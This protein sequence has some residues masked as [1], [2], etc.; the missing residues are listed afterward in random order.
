MPPLPIIVDFEMLE[1]R[2][3]GLL[4]GDVD[5]SS[6]ALLFEQ[7]KERFHRRIIPTIAFAGHTHDHPR[8]FQLVPI[9]VT[10]VLAPSI[11]VMQESCLGTATAERHLQRFGYQFLIAGSG[12]GPTHDRSRIPIQDHRQ[13]Q[14]AMHGRDVG[15]ICHPLLVRLSGRKLSVE[16]VRSDGV[17]D[18]SAGSQCPTV[19]VASG[20]RCLTHQ[21]GDPF[22]RDPSSLIPQFSLNTRTAISTAVPVVNLLDLLR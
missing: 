11:T 18:I 3:P 1:K 7:A 9:R 19:F 13:I 20:E 17:R 6:H 12:H 10:G 16:N 14:P 21:P 8:L 15:D 2:L 5:E 4:M 22:A